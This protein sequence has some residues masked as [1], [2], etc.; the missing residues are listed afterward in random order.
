MSES[1]SSFGRL[2]NPLRL[3][4]I[5]RFPPTVRVSPGCVELARNRTNWVI[6]RGAPGISFL[7]ILEFTQARLGSTYFGVLHSVY[8]NGDLQGICGE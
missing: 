6:P 4:L 5:F 7:G 1:F 8:G 2:P 3:A